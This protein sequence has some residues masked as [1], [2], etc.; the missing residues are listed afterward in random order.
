MWPYVTFPFVGAILGAFLYLLH[1]YIDNLERK[2]EVEQLKDS[3]SP[4]QSPK[5]QRS[6]VP[7]S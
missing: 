5:S 4:V 6:S 2:S 1:C 7:L 3:S